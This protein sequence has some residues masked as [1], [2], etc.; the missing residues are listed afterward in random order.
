[1][2]ILAIEN[3]IPGF[4]AD[5]FQPHLH[6]EA[7]RI[8]Q[9]HKGGVIREIYFRADRHE[10]VLILECRDELEAQAVIDTLPLVEA[11]L[12]TFELI[13]LVAYDG[14]ERLFGKRLAL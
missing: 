6:E 4:S 11:G 5:D 10:A 1:M 12:V 7:Q 3:E 13:P 8:W 9:L 2:K 14:Y